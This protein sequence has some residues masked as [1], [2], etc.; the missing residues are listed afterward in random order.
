VLG[1][2]SLAMPTIESAASAASLFEA[3]EGLEVKNLAIHSG[4]MEVLSRQ[5][6][7][8]VAFYENEGESLWNAHLLVIPEFHN[9]EHLTIVGPIESFDPDMY[10]EICERAKDEELFWAMPEIG[11]IIEEIDDSDSSVMSE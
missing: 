8:D 11:Y 7:D 2:H 9:L 1:H 4:L 10:E 3:A 5:L 6:A